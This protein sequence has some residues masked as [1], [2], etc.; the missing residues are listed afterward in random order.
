MNLDFIFRALL[1]RPFFR[2]QDRLFNFL[3][4]RKLFNKRECTV[5]P[6]NGN[7]KINCDPNTWIG[8]RIIFLGDYEPP[9]KKVFKDHIKAGD[10]VLDIGANIG[11]H[12]LYFSELVGQQGK[13][14]AFE[15][16]PANFEQ[17]KKNIALNHFQNIETNPVALS[18]KNEQLT[19]AAD[20]GS[21]NPGAYNLFD[22]NGTIAIDCRIGD[23]MIGNNRVDFI[24]IDVEGYESFVLDGLSQ[25]IEK[26]R[27]TIVFEYDQNYQRKTGQADDVIFKLLGADRYTF[28]EIKQ[29]G[30]RQLDQFG[31]ISSGNILAVPNV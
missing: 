19:I 7:F 1:R 31:S 15:P 23:E 13:V 3:F 5:V 18:N 10:Q 29:S 20:E 17:L 24:K 8:A 11:F 2:G 30:L 12:T 28:F 9:L 21:T 6:L 27:P 16:V 26:N 22:R 25:T 14:T 4:K